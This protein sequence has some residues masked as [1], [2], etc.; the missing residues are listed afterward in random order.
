MAVTQRRR[1]LLHAH[2]QA[3]QRY[4]LLLVTLFVPAILLLVIG[5][6]LLRSKVATTTYHLTMT[7][8]SFSGANY[9]LAQQ[10]LVPGAQAQHVDLTFVATGGSE[11]TLN[12]VQSGKVQVAI[13]DGLSLIH[14]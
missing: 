3:R 11:D 1:G 10:Y 14:I 6:L 4:I 12:A 5:G 7:T 9:S 2:G 13:V 8:G